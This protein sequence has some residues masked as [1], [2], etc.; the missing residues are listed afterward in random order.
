MKSQVAWPIEE[1]KKLLPRI[2]KHKTIIFETGYGPSGLPHIGTFGEVVRTIMV[3]KALEYLSPGVDMKLICFSDDMDGLRKVPDNVPNP[4]EVEKYLGHALTSI[5]DPFRTHE[6]YGAHMNARL[7]SFLDLFGFQYEFKSATECYQRGLFDEQL[8]LVL[9]NNRRILDL[10]LP[11]LGDERQQT[12]SP[13]LPVR[14]GRVLQAKVMELKENSIIYEDPSTGALMESGVTGGA[15][16]LQWKVD[17]GMRWAALG[18]DFEFHGKDLTPSAVLSAKIAK[19]LGSTPPE[20]SVYELFLD[21]EG[22]KISKSKGN[23]LTIEEWLT[24]APWESLAFFMFQHPKRAKRLYFDIIPKNV[25]DYLRFLQS[26]SKGDLTNP[27]SFI[28]AKDKEIAKGITYSLLLNLASACNPENPGVLW[29]FIQRYNPLVA[30]ENSPLLDR[31]VKH[32]IS[33]YR[34]FVEPSK[35]YRKPTENEFKALM[36]LADELKK[37]PGDAIAEEIQQLVYSVG[38]ESGYSSDIKVWFQVLYQILLGQSEG[39]RIGS[40]IA[41]YGVANTIAMIEK[42]VLR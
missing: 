31:L 19:I 40:F 22:K 13:F 2:G 37:I 1:A 33:Y 39:P 23:G 32:A 12:Y 38:K 7:M 30:P 34:D 11:T 41:L 20:L 29:G 24:Y 8:L 18:V 25:D 28:D 27:L 16:K 36:L 21:E 9:R 14:D 5:P 35:N 15:C 3:M 26:F 6:S 4:E 10:I 42:V 17:W